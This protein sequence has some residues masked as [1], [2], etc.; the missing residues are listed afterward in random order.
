MCCVCFTLGSSLGGLSKACVGNIGCMKGDKKEGE[1]RRCLWEDSYQGWFRR[2]RT[3]SKTRFGLWVSKIEERRIRGTDQPSYDGKLILWIAKSMKSMSI[4]LLHPLWFGVD[5]EESGKLFH[6][7]P[8]LSTFT[9][10]PCHR[11]TW[12]V[13]F[14]YWQTCTMSYLKVSFWYCP[15]L[16]WLNSYDVSLAPWADSR[17]QP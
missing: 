13:F 9:L 14:S 1:V 5:L 4:C 11:F 6:K 2:A 10:S 16:F 7:G 17:K 12:Y 3:C 15:N 8:G